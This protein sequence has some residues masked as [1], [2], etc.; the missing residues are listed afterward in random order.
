ME[1]EIKLKDNRRNVSTS[2]RGHQMFVVNFLIQKSTKMIS[3]LKIMPSQK[4]LFNQTG[5]NGHNSFSNKM[6]F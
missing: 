3:H 6:L 2:V 1:K 5:K 4:Q